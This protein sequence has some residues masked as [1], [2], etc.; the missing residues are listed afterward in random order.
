[1]ESQY[2]ETD[3]IQIPYD[4]LSFLAQR[5]HLETEELMRIFIK[6]VMIGL[7]DRKNQELMK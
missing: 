2:G 4:I 7:K 3:S 1:M 6:G 5:Y